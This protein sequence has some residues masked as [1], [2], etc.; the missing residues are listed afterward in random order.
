MIRLHKEYLIDEKGKKKA[1]LL[2]YDEWQKILED[3]EELE[4][5]RAYDKAKSEPSDPIPF[6]VAVKEIKQV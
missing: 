3:L 6:D 5:I 1:V 4:E 2:P